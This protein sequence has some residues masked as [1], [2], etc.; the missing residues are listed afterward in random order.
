MNFFTKRKTRAKIFKD[1]EFLGYDPIKIREVLNNHN[2]FESALKV[3]SEDK[4]NNIQEGLIKFGIPNKAAKILSNQFQDLP[5]A[6]DYYYEYENNIERI[7]K[8]LSELDYHPRF[9][10]MSI[11]NL[12][13]VDRAVYECGKNP[14]RFGSIYVNENSEER[15]VQR[16][17]GIANTVLYI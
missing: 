16:E 2:D 12:W 4:E 11:T 9:I 3:L 15:K 10:E 7:K 6:L 5:Q 17:L 14:R 8:E 13:S 1:L